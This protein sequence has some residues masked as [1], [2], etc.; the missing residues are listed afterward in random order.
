MPL[1]K[2]G[3]HRESPPI[4]LRPELIPSPRCIAQWAAPHFLVHVKWEY[5]T[6]IGHLSASYSRSP[7]DTPLPVACCTELLGRRIAQ[8]AV[9]PHRIVLPAIP[10]PLRTRIRHRLELLPLQE[11]VAQ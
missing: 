7:F 3:G 9:R 6:R 1:Y 8:R 2:S 11:L 4:D 10:R 5:A